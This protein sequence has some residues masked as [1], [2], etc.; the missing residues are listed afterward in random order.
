MQT[1]RRKPPAG[2]DAADPRRNGV[3]EPG[4]KAE[5]EREL[6]R[7]PIVLELRRLY[8]G[9]DDEPLPSYLVEL[10]RKLEE[11]ERSR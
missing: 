5:S 1:Q 3:A 2:S 4:K 7:D 9:V 10:L 11:V 6:E 8:D